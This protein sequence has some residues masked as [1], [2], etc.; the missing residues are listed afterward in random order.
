MIC[1][2]RGPLSNRP[3]FGPW[4]ERACLVGGVD[5]FAQRAIVGMHHQRLVHRRL[6]GDAQSVGLGVLCR[7]FQQG[8]RRFGQAG[9]TR[10]ALGQ[11]Q[12]PRFGGIEH[13]LLEL[14][15]QP[16]QLGGD[17]PVALLLVGRQVDAGQAEVE[18]GILDQLACGR[19]QGVEIG[20]CA[21][22]THGRTQARVLTDLGAE[23]GQQLDR[24]AIRFAPFRRVAHI[25]QMPDRREAAVQRVL[26]V[27]PGQHQR[28]EAMLRRIRNQSLDARTAIGDARL[29]GRHHVLRP[30]IGVGDELVVAQQGVGSG[31]QTSPSKRTTW[32]RLALFASS[33]SIRA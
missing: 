18:Q 5:L 3:A 29:D 1:S 30:D 26:A 4:S 16:R 9:Q 11:I 24:L 19:R 21:D 13:G 12:R 25:V 32:R 14:G 33:R 20:A 17:R 7:L 10:I 2:M 8:Q 23:V 6:Q 15:R 28:V 22:R 27:F 31:H